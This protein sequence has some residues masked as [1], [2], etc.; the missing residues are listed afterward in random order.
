MS[1]ILCD[2]YIYI[3]NIKKPPKIQIQGSSFSQNV[4]LAHQK[5]WKATIYQKKE[6][7]PPAIMFEKAAVHQKRFT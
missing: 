7:W 6:A 5:N 4:Y 2:M 3:K 1:N